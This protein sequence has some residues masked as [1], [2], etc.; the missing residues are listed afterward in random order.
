MYAMLQM[1]GKIQYGILWL[2]ILVFGQYKWGWPGINCYGSKHNTLAPNKYTGQS[3]I[4]VE[5]NEKSHLSCIKSHILEGIDASN[6]SSLS[7]A[8]GAL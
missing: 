7:P 3:F 4:A 6:N 5:W 1:Y 2:S 8:C